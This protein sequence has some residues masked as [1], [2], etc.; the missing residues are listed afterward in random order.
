A[1]AS[2][3]VQSGCCN[4]DTSAGVGYCASVCRQGYGRLAGINIVDDNVARCRARSE[5]AGSYRAVLHMYRS[6]ALL[7]YSSR[8][9]HSTGVR[10]CP[11]G[12]VN[13]TCG[14]TSSNYGYAATVSC[15][16]SSC[17]TAG[18]TCTES[19]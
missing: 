1:S 5:P 4:C 11:C 17:D 2:F 13:G 10:K 3:E 14:H 8:N 16:A 9:V 12:G 15:A 6:A 19:N 7:G 18:C